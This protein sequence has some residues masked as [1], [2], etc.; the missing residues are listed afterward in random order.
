MGLEFVPR[1]LALLLLEI[2]S[3]SRLIKLTA[4]SDEALTTHALGTLII[5][6]YKTD[7][8]DQK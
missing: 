6:F 5:A 7:L 1:T 8:T 3:L 2:D 4:I